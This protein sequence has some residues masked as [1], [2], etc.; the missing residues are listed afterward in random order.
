MGVFVDH[1]NVQGRL[2][3]FHIRFIVKTQVYNVLF[4]NLFAYFTL[5][6]RGNSNQH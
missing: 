6:P 1:R 3:P 2:A 5:R 4:G